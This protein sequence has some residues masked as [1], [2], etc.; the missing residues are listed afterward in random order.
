M[1][2]TYPNLDQILKAHAILRQLGDY[3]TSI[4]GAVGEVYAQDVLKMEKAGRGQAGYDG[5]IG[6]K[7]VSVKTKE[8]DKPGR[9]VELSEKSRGDVD[10]LLIVMLCSDG[11]IVH[12]GPIP[13]SQ[14][15]DRFAKGPRIP[16]SH[17]EKKLAL[18][19]QDLG[20]RWK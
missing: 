6:N 12:Y 19:P 9:Y 11:R 1:S 10:E 20:I 14:L 16:V 8:S 4:V 18:P 2:T 15:A 13:I 7:R 3:D 5:I 17:V